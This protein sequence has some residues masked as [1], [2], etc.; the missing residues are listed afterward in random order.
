MRIKKILICLI[1]LSMSLFLGCEQSVPVNIYLA[2]YYVRNEEIDWYVQLSKDNTDYCFSN[3]N[4]KKVDGKSWLKEINSPEDALLAFRNFLSS[5]Q[6]FVSAYCKHANNEFDDKYAANENVQNDP[7]YIEHCA[8]YAVTS[9]SNKEY[10]LI[11]TYND[12]WHENNNY[13]Y[14]TGIVYLFNKKGE[15]I[16]VVMGE[17]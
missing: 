13:H 4:F 17:L 1:A 9:D 15:I 5:D 6:R 8:P 16:Y 14:P 10:W 12:D 2:G 3:E 11:E 7:L